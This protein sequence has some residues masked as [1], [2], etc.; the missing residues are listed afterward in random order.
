M[1]SM[2]Q[3][4]WNQPSP[5]WTSLSLDERAQA[6]HM[7]C[8][9]TIAYFRRLGLTS[10]IRSGQFATF[11]WQYQATGAGTVWYTGSVTSALGDSPLAISTLVTIR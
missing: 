7:Y 2:L 4:D 11:R 1:T 10:R 3:P 9:D 6:I 8:R 5:E